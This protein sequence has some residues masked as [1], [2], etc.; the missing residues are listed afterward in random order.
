MQ[1]VPVIGISWIQWKK[2]NAYNNVTILSHNMWAYYW[3]NEK[4]I[5]DLVVKKN[6]IIL[7]IFKFS[8]KKVQLISDIF[9]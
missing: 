5:L 4:I 9:V 8:N 3:R 7:Q 1:L 2:L 6:V